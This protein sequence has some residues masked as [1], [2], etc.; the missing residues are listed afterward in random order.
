[1]SEEF[2]GC[3]EAFDWRYS[4]AIV[5]LWRYLEYHELPFNKDSI[6]R[7]EER[8]VLRYRKE[9]ITEERDVL[10][11]RKED[12]TEERYLKFAEYFYN[13][14]FPHWKAEK[15]L[16]HGNFNDETVKEINALLTYNVVLKKI[17]SKHKFDGEN[18]EELL[19]ILNENRLEIIRET[20][21][22][23]TNMYRNY[24]NTNQLFHEPQEVCRLN[25][26][27][28]DWGKK[29]KSASYYRNDKN[30]FLGKD[31]SEFDFIPFA[32]TEYMD[33]Y[34]INDSSSLL[35]L[36]QANER[37]RQA[38][39]QVKQ[40]TEAAGKRF[41]IKQVLFEQLVSSA[42][43]LN[44][45]VELI[46]KQRDNDYFETI[47]LRK[48]SIWIFKS[49]ESMKNRNVFNWSFKITEDYYIKV[50]DEVMDSIVN[51]KKLDWLIEFVL[52][53]EEED[54]K[55]YFLLKALIQVNIKIYAFV[56][57]G[58]KMKQ[59]EIEDCA[60]K[61]ANKIEENK[62]AAYRNK[63][64]SSLVFKDY[65]RVCQILL[66]LSNYSNI[67][68]DCLIS[69]LE[70]CEEHKNNVYLFIACLRKQGGEE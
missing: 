20:F 53:K 22:N 63:L 23:K 34:F 55:H 31:I 16:K 3:L 42:D 28:V 14:E 21:R 27:Y 54:K 65:D 45:D 32:F 58:E 39:V 5:G 6:Q 12:I 8:D 59:K 46:S 43:F 47:F 40:E 36:V 38:L 68:L 37:M 50:L 1:M 62:L 66:Q 13:E 67:S 15:M 57:G 18:A 69:T 61:I 49:L 60:R 4:A 48:K 19:T 51:L 44:Y 30:F 33:G 11:Y 25:G 2:D 29:G 56:D 7:D 70:N 35:D 17:F 9:D 64:T 26:Y 52:K 41:T 10:R 24:C